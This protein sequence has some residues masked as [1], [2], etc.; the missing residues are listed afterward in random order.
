M[1]RR[2]TLLVNLLVALGLVLSGQVAIAPL[3]IETSEARVI[4]PA[5]AAETVDAPALANRRANRQQHHRQDLRKDRRQDRTQADRQR[6]R[7]QKDR[8][9]DRKSAD[10]A[11]GPGREGDWREFCTG[12]DS[13]RLPKV[14]LC[15]HGADPAPAGLHVDQPVELSSAETAKPAPASPVCEGDGQSGYRV[16]VL[17]VYPDNQTSRF[18]D[19]LVAKL[20]VLAAQADQI[21]RASA[22]ETGAAR[23]LR[24]FHDAGEPCQLTVADVKI[25]A[26][27]I[28]RFD[29]MITQ[30]RAQGYNRTDR[31]YLAFTDATNYCGVGTLWNDD[32]A[33]SANWNYSGPS[34]SRVD[35]GCWTGMVAAH[36]VMHNLGGVQNS[37]P[38]ASGGF[39]C[40]DEY[41]VMCYS[42]AGSGLPKMRFDCDESDRNTTFFDCGHNDYFHT[43][44]AP[45]SY[46]ANYWNPT[47]NRFLIGANPPPP[48]PPPPP[49]IT[50][51]KQK[52]DNQGKKGKSKHGNGKKHK[53]KH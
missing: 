42:D 53:K 1:R 37:A 45:G 51:K 14:D 24:F 4:A 15:I 13:T 36:E 30:L 18:N 41:D 44:P 26:G 47:N 43:N 34:Y 33:N 31:I 32:R 8:Q 16:Q 52:K 11:Q 2:R 46:L 19:S 17:Y 3:P 49:D 22:E 5:G 21:F 7:K 23:N 38:N 25:P 20:R 9:H 27:S 39:H 48:P 40:I 6:D 10:N 35:A 50:E 12:P 29:T 28:G